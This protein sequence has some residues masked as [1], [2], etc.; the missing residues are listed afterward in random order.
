MLNLWH[1]GLSEQNR[2]VTVED[3]HRKLIRKPPRTVQEA[4]WNKRADKFDR[5]VQEAAKNGLQIR[6]IINDGRRRKPGEQKPSRVQR[7]QLDPVPWAVTSYDQKTG[8][9]V[10]RRGAAARRFADQFSVPP[11]PESKAERRLVSG[12][13]YVRDAVFRDRALER[14]QGKCEFCGKPGFTMPDGKV[15]LETHHVVPLSDDGP[16]AE[17]NVA[18]ICPNHHREAH[19]GSRAAEIRQKLLEH[20][21]K[22]VQKSRLKSTT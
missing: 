8:D 19:H 12:M 4:M 1:D 2:V 18:A 20:L 7:R 13:S 17:D 15:F 6:A 11:E 9:F 21:R 10:L 22:H 3:N 14:A 16:D 5:A